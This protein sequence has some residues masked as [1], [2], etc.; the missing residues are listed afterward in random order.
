MNMMSYLQMMVMAALASDSENQLP[1]FSVSPPICPG[2]CK[3]SLLVNAYPFR[4]L[5]MAQFYQRILE[6]RRVFQ[7]SQEGL[8]LS[9]GSSSAASLINGHPTF[10]EVSQYDH[11]H[12]QARQ[13]TEQTYIS[14]KVFELYIHLFAYFNKYNIFSEFYLDPN[15]YRLYQIQC[16]IRC[17]ASTLFTLFFHQ[18]NIWYVE[19]SNSFN[20]IFVLTTQTQKCLEWDLAHIHVII[21]LFSLKKFYF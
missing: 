9:P 13:T 3:Y 8:L 5:R 20:A 14:L 21:F 11:I 16:E 17:R 12:F 15:K 2:V 19:V 1:V 4:G 7:F 6:L 18:C 10:L